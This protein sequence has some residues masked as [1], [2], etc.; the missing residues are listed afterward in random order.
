MKDNTED[1]DHESDN[2]TLEN[3]YEQC[4]EDLN[5]LQR[6]IIKTQFGLQSKFS[7]FQNKDRLAWLIINN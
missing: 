2:G 4:M 3:G 1:D 6:D 5:D 7:N